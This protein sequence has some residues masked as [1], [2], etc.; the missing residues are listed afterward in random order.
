M[1]ISAT[2]LYPTSKALELPAMRWEVATSEPITSPKLSIS[3]SDGTETRVVPLAIVKTAPQ[4]ITGETLLK[5]VRFREDLEGDAYTITAV[6]LNG[7]SLSQPLEKA[8]SEPIEKEAIKA[9]EEIEYGAGYWVDK[10]SDFIMVHLPGLLK[11][12][13]ASGVDAIVDEFNTIF[14]A[15]TN[16]SR[17]KDM[18][19]LIDTVAN[20]NEGNWEFSNPD[21]HDGKAYYIEADG[22]YI[23]VR[24]TPYF[25]FFDHFDPATQWKQIKKNSLP[26]NFQVQWAY[27][28]LSFK[29]YETAIEYTDPKKPY[30]RWDPSEAL[31]GPTIETTIPDSN[32]PLIK[33]GVIET[34][35]TR[36]Y[37][38]IPKGES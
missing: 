2:S 10:D 23:I 32:I 21:S 15:I 3:V 29:K 6:H 36:V 19:E 31:A 38:Y 17:V 13:P 7:D 22:E 28:P 30:L 34:E 18:A 20:L 16:P 1:I 26:Y 24:Q 27:T 5:D 14:P 35:K 37:L 9:P 33:N 12:D 8:V 25:L 11:W 4:R